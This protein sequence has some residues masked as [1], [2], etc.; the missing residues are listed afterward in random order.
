MRVNFTT[1][2]HDGPRRVFSRFLS[3]DKQT[4]RPV[5]KNMGRQRVTSWSSFMQSGIKE[6]MESS[7]QPHVLP[8]I[9]QNKIIF[10]QSIGR[11]YVSIVFRQHIQYQNIHIL[12]CHAVLQDL[13]QIEHVWDA[14]KR[15]LCDLPSPPH[16]PPHNIQQLASALGA[17]WNNLPQHF[18][19]WLVQ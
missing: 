19:A 13:S 7:G 1:N 16:C 17:I 12:P 5:N 6:S 4:S 18:L 14:M 11:S 15:R 3:T 9:F 8:F 10:Q 2:G